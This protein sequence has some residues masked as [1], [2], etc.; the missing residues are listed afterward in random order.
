MW[1]EVLSLAEKKG[2]AVPIDFIVGLFIFLVLLAYFF[3]L[4][5]IYSIRYFETAKS[6]DRDIASLSI[7]D[8]LVNSPGHPENWAQDPLNAQAIGLCSRPN[9]L[10]SE[11]IAAF[12]SIPYA[13]AKQMLGIDEEFFVKI[14]T[15]EGARYASIGVE[16]NNSSTI[17]EVSRVALL[18]NTIVNVR[19]QLYEN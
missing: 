17:L 10:S 19:V 18:N 8:A 5:D 2:Q 13:N 14:E 1:K 7:T 15:S 16:A 12:S 6:R 9:E 11:K 4:W 3:I